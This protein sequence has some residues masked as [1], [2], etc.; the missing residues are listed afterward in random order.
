VPGAAV[1]AAMTVCFGGRKLGTAVEPGRSRAGTVVTVDIGLPATLAGAPEALRVD[2]GDLDALPTRSPTGTKY[3]AGAVLVVGGSPGLSG[4]PSLASQAA[5]HAGAGV[6]WACVPREDQAAVAHHAAE[7]MVHGDLGDRAR[8]LELAGRADV[9]VLGPGLGRDAAAR[10]LVDALVDGVRTTL[11]C[12]ADA[13]FALAGRLERLQYRPAPTALT[14]HAGELGRLLGR[15]AADISAHRLACVREAADRA[16]CAVLLK[17]PDT[18]VAAPGE[19][20]RVVE[21]AVPAL[22]TAGAGDVLS[23]VSAAVLARGVPTAE[24][25]ALAAAAHGAAARVAATAAGTIV[26]SDLFGP[27]GRL[28]APSR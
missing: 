12:D 23:G 4:A 18:L 22:A 7:I 26:A 16:Q 15:P 25:L 9:V 8:V 27:V 2:A 17:G 21:T 20:L 24:G 5:L 19:P 28:L 14:P 1:H 11:L 3:D 13:L 6:V 10:E